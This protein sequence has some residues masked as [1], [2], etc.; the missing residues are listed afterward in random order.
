MRIVHVT[1]ASVRG[2]V[3]R[4]VESLATAQ[5]DRHQ[6]AV[7]SGPGGRPDELTAAVPW[8]E[9]SIRGNSDFRGV[10]WLLRRL[11]DLQA[12]AVVFHACAPGELV[13]AAAI[14][15]KRRSTVMLEHLPQYHPLGTP[16]RNRMYARLGRKATAW[17]AV[18]RAGGEELERRWGLASGTIQPLYLGV[19]EPV[20]ELSESERRMLANGEGAVVL[21]LGMPEARKGFDTFLAAAELSRQRFAARWVW[22]GGQAAG[23]HGAVQILPWSA[24]VGGWLR[25]AE[26]VLVPSRAEG[27]P[28]VVLEAF[29][30]G[31][32]VVASRVGGIPEAVEHDANGLLL[33][34]EDVDGWCRTVEQVLLDRNLHQRLGRAGRRTWEQRFTVDAMTERM[35]NLLGS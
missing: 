13:L 6:V 23:T 12:D 10:V 2:G 14:S 16:L 34:P 31:T 26:L 11:R 1:M 19:A 15:A 21:G 9:R 27:L 5:A 29:A 30:C 17:R 35:E 25:A 3:L 20:S 33:P 8:E 7:I 24:H 28:L 4:V 18:S 32:P 22:V